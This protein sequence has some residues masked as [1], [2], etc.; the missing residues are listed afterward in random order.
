MTRKGCADAV[1]GYVCY[2]AAGLFALWVLSSL[3]PALIKD[4]NDAKSV[5]VPAI[6]IFAAIGA[7]AILMLMGMWRKLKAWIVRNWRSRS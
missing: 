1:I 6:P 3:F 5:V 4:R 7:I 2:V